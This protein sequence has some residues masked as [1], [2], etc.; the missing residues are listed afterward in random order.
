MKK[1]IIFILFLIQFSLWSQN[2]NKKYY[3]EV[4][5]VNTNANNTVTLIFNDTY[6]TNLFSNYTIHSF[7]LAFPGAKRE[8]LTR[9]YVI[10]CYTDLITELNLNYSTI[11]K[12]IVE[13]PE[14]SPLFIP[15]DLGFNG[16]QPELDFIGAIQ[17]WDITQGNS[18]VLVGINDLGLNTSQE[19]LTGKS[20]VVDG[21]AI[22]GNSSSHGTLVASAC[23]A[24]TNNNTGMAAVG[25]NCNIRST[26][27]GFSGLMPLVNSGVRVINMS[28]GSCQTNPVIYEY[29]L[30]DEIWEDRGVVLVAAAG[31]GA[32]SCPAGAQYDHFPA[33]YNHVI[34]VTNVGHQYPIGTP[35]VNENYWQD[36]F[37]GS[38]PPYYATHNPNVDLSAPG[39]NVL[40]VTHT[41]ANAYTYSGGT[42]VSAPIVTGTI[43]LMFS[44]N[45]CLFP[46]EVESILKL[47]VV[48]ND[49]L[50]QNL[51]YQGRIGAGRLDVLR[52]VDMARDMADNFGTVEVFDRVI[53]RW[54]FVL[55]T[56]PYNIIL[57]NNVVTNN[58]TIDFTARNN[59][60]VI[61]GDYSPT[62]TGFVDLKINPINTKCNIPQLPKYAN[63]ENNF[64][65]IDL[66]LFPNPNKGSFTISLPKEMKDIS[67]TVFDTFGK[68]VY[69]TTA[70]GVSFD[71]DVPNLPSGL[72]LVKLH[73][74]ELNETL[75]FIKE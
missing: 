62:N 28:W 18:N 74:N 51:L 19:D 30:L 14:F 45:S 59:I 61:S 48:R 12:G 49:N 27:L 25:F 7:S 56:S 16:A 13:V 70:N 34:S 46:D 32:F 60:E 6:L 33:S 43:G 8:L 21:S 35:G 71:I 17:A 2:G 5:T 40:T 58:A 47:T 4:H 11:F 3:M 31:N 73:S 67:V 44:I 75:K 24:N 38:T 72:Y 69:E 23:A 63:T 22:F 42:S 1:I 57:T 64:K 41:A 39:R 55:K 36:V 10:D 26:G 37:L 68:F 53:D 66:K 50:P 15:N 29:A 20:V 9:V 54:N 52:A 65:S